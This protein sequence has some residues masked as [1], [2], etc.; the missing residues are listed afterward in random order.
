MG[1]DRTAD[2]AFLSSFALVWSQ[3]LRLFP[4][5]ITVDALN[6]AVPGVG[7]LGAVKRARE[8]LVQEEFDVHQL[9]EEVQ[10][11]PAGVRRVRT[12]IPTLEEMSQE[13]TK[14]LQKRLANIPATLDSLRLRILALAGDSRTRAWYYSVTSADT[15]APDFWRVIPTYPAMQVSPTH[16]PIAARS[17]LFQHQPVLGGLSSCHKCQREVDAEG[18]HLFNCRPRKQWGLGHPFVAVHNRVVGEV[19]SALRKVYHGK[20]RVEKHTGKTGG[21]RPDIIVSD[22]QGGELMV[23]VSIIRPMADSRWRQAAQGM[24]LINHESARR[25]DYNDLR[26]GAT[27]VPFVCDVLGGMGP[28]TARFVR[29]MAG[30]MRGRGELVQAGAPTWE[31]LLRRNLSMVLAKSR[32]ELLCSRAAAEWGHARP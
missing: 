3:T 1:A 27:M 30:E 24:H 10:V 23:E 28:E 6:D 21:R 4:T 22:H 5:V 7:R 16:F 25:D 20:V 29:R 13:S 26:P 17:Y 14:G 9:L 31:E 19:A 2:A 8:R 12:E 15:V 18:M 11:L 32:A